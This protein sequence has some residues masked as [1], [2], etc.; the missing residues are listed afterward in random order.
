VLTGTYVEETVTELSSG[1]DLAHAVYDIVYHT[2][3]DATVAETDAKVAI[4]ARERR[5][6]RPGDVHFL[7]ATTFH[8]AEPPLGLLTSTLVVTAPVTNRCQL[9]GDAGYLPAKTT[10]DQFPSEPLSELLHALRAL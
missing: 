2:R 3:D 5:T 7:E 8:T 1:G 10:R 6:Y 4:R 9:L